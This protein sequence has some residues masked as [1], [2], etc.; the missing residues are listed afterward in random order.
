MRIYR[1]TL[2]CVLRIKLYG[3]YLAGATFRDGAEINP[4]A[5]VAYSIVSRQELWRRRHDG[6]AVSL[7]YTL[8]RS[9]CG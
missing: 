9:S 1:T 6:S 3:A 2:S 7:M 5:A 4:R 8:R